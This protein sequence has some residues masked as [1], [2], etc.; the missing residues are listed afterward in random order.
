MHLNNLN[1][2]VLNV[3]RKEAMRRPILHAVNYATWRHLKL[4]QEC[5]PA[6]TKIVWMC[7]KMGTQNLEETFWDINVYK[8]KYLNKQTNF[9]MT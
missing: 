2:P 8:Y 6:K 9:N 1:A 4:T 7:M 5:S 3:L